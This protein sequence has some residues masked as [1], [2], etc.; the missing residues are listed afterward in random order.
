[1]AYFRHRTIDFEINRDMDDEGARPAHGDESFLGRIPELTQRT[2]A[3]TRLVKCVNSSAVYPS[4]FISFEGGEAA[5][6]STQIELL[7]Y[8]LRVERELIVSPKNAR[9]LLRGYN[10]GAPNDRQS[11]TSPA[12]P[13]RSPEPAKRS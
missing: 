12:L 1:M 4:R 5:G 3:S 10:P 11:R 7:A 9:E 8:H 13:A 2:F 6:K